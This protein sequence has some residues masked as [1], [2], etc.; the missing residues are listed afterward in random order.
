MTSLMAA[1]TIA[2]SL[3]D[4][5]RLFAPRARRLGMTDGEQLGVGIQEVINLYVSQCRAHAA[6]MTA[7]RNLSQG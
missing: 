5:Q 2:Q 6:G 1:S 3:A 4:A 7:G